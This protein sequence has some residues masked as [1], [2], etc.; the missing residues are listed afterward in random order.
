MN[1]YRLGFKLSS[2]LCLFACLFGTLIC[3]AHGG[4]SYYHGGGGN[5]YHGHG[6]YYGGGGWGWGGPPVVIAVPF[7]GGHYEPPVYP[8]PCTIIRECYPDHT[9]I[10]REICE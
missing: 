8:A 6:G 9:C 10:E 5:Y 1:T 2:A 4:G 3:S 7:G